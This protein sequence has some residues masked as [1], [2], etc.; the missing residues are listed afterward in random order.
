MQAVSS[1]YIMAAPFPL[2]KSESE[3]VTHPIEK[4]TMAA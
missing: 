4:Q 2:I 1:R 3:M